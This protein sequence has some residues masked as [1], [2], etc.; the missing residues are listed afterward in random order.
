MLFFLD[1]LVVLILL[2]ITMRAV[3]RAFR[4]RIVCSS[5]L[6]CGV[7]FVFY[8]LP[9]VYDWFSTGALVPD[10]FYMAWSSRRVRFIYD[11]VLLSSVLLIK[12]GAY[13]WSSA[14]VVN[15]VSTPA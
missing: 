3:L 6:I 1:S 10:W 5:D 12:L 8:G 9:L 4:T 14:S 13:R 2:V 7:L 15:A 11:F